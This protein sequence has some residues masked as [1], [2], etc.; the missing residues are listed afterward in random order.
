VENDKKQADSN[1][2]KKQM[3]RTIMRK[4][5][6]ISLAGALLF[7]LV[8]IVLL[9][10]MQMPYVEQHDEQTIV[11]D[12]AVELI[13]YQ[14]MENGSLQKLN[15]ATKVGDVLAFK[16]ST[17]LPIYVTLAASINKQQPTLLFQTT[18]IPPGRERLLERAFALFTYK[19][20]PDDKSIKFCAIYGQEGQQLQMQLRDL[21]KIWPSLSASSCVQIF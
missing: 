20:K 21:S 6:L 9:K 13:A 5:T 16:L 14:R 15:Q 2:S 1:V 11:Q 10:D 3:Q 4:S 19:I 8:A 18:R 7:A 17:N 12:L